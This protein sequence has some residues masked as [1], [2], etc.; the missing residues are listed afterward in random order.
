MLIPT[1][2]KSL[3][4]SCVSCRCSIWLIFCLPLSRGLVLKKNLSLKDSNYFY[5][6]SWS[7]VIHMKE[8]KYSFFL[9]HN[10][11]EHT[12]ITLITFF[13]ITKLLQMLLG[14]FISDL[15]RLF[16]RNTLHGLNVFN[17]VLNIYMS[18]SENKDWTVH[19]VWTEIMLEIFC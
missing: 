14:Q 8:F 16:S 3:F 10:E 4:S 15:C 18:H 17:A 9:K 12:W 1:F 6:R 5:F 7:L 13:A 19:S 2:Q 11:G